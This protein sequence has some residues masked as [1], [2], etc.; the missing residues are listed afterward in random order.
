M[1]RRA[2]V[3][4]YSHLETGHKFRDLFQR[5]SFVRMQRSPPPFRLKGGE[6]HMH[7]NKTEKNTIICPL[8]RLESETT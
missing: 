1:I 6:A 8:D 5:Q 2:I 3:F 4:I 7:I